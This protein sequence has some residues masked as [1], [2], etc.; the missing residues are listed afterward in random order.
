VA[1]CSNCGCEGHERLLGML[2]VMMGYLRGGHERPEMHGLHPED[3]TPTE[4]RV[5]CA[6]MPP[7][8]LTEYETIW[9]RAWGPERAASKTQDRTLIRVVISRMRPEV[10]RAGWNIQVIPKYGVQLIRAPKE[11]ENGS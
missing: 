10:A 3:F 7:G 4:Y 9:A 1:R 6:L 5:L 2:D 11:S 8:T